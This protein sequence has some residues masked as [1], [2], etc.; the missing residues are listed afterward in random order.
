VLDAIAAVT[1]MRRKNYTM[2]VISHELQQ[3]NFKLLQSAHTHSHSDNPLGSRFQLQ[4]RMESMATVIHTLGVNDTTFICRLI[5][6]GWR[7]SSG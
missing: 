1:M 6:T 5:E 3:R 7:Y 4:Q 2:G